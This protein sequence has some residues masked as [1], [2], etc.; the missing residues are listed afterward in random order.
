MIEAL[1][2]IGIWFKQKFYEGFQSERRNPPFEDH[3]NSVIEVMGDY[4]LNAQKRLEKNDNTS[5]NS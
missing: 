3:I 4:D 2:F 5:I 1:K